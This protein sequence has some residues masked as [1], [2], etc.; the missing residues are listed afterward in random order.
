MLSSP[1][2]LCCACR[3]GC[4]PRCIVLPPCRRGQFG[5]RWRA[6]ALF[7]GAA[8]PNAQRTFLQASAR[9]RF[10]RSAS[11]A[12]LFNASACLYL[13]LRPPCRLT[14]RS[15]RGP[16]AKHRARLP[17]LHIIRPAGPALRRRPRLTSNVRQRRYHLQYASIFS[18]CRRKLNSHDAA[19]PRMADRT[20]NL[21]LGLTSRRPLH[22]PE[23][24]RAS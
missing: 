7:S 8:P 4:T 11:L 24:W 10:A 15:R 16:T 19:K 18:A 23:G 12:A 3:L 6:S 22:K 2:P 17:A 14:P 21:S 9:R 1:C 5:Q 13:P 20:R